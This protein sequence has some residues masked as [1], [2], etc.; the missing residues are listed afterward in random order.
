MSSDSVLTSV[1]RPDN[2]N[3]KSVAMYN[4][5]YRMR[6]V[7]ISN[8][9]TSSITL[10][11]S[12]TQ[13][14]EFKLPANQVWNPARSSI[15]YVLNIPAQTAAYTWN[16]EDT[17]EI[18][19][20][21]QFCNASG[22]YLTDLQYANNYI[23]AAHKVDIDQEDFEGGDVTGVLYKA[24]VP[25]V[26]AA[27]T[28]AAGSNFFPPRAVMPAVNAYNMAA[29][30]A[31][32]AGCSALTT[33][34]PQYA[35]VCTTAATAVVLPRSI[36]LGGITQTAVGMDRDFIF[37]E[38]MYIRMQIAPSSKVAY[39]TL[40]ATDPT[41]T[42]IALTVQPTI[43][44]M[45]LQLAMQ[46]DPVVEASVRAKFMSGTLSYTIPYVYAWKNTTASGVS[47]VQISLNNQYGHKLKRLLHVP[48]AS[49]ES[50]N[51]AYDHQ[52]LNGAKITS[53]QTY[54][55]SQPLQDS[56]ISCLQPTGTA[57]NMDDFRENR[58]LLRA[59]AIENSLAYYYNWCHIDSFSQPK[60]GKVL[61][62]SENIIEGLDL[63]MPRQWTLTANA[64]VTLNQYTFGTFIREV[65]ASPQGTQVVVV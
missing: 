16:F 32:P 56:Q 31:A 41:A 10:Q 35:R 9:T 29:T 23:S 8:M 22:V 53:Y 47:S 6:K 54:I 27:A 57:L 63:S 11:P 25:W 52:N 30:G 39:T 24:T 33:F 64:A 45:Y 7:P 20:A 61:T 55:D 5:R 38:D 58:P 36:P 59:S 19:G 4:G 48:I 65:H 15:D 44:Y 51:V 50:L 21:I 62:P 40:S 2:L 42:P 17:F 13:L 26:T 34:E 18:C 28:P 3:Y 49:A 14:V 46:V 12:A 37:C 1:P 43:S 60:R